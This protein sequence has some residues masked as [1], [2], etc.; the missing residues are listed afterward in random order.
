M[1]LLF[2]GPR[3]LALH[4]ENELN[5]DLL[6]PLFSKLSQRSN[7]ESIYLHNR[8]TQQAQQTMSNVFPTLP[9]LRYLY[10]S[11]NDMGNVLKALSIPLSTGSP[12]APSLLPCPQLRTV[13][14]SECEFE[15]TTERL[16]GPITNQPTL[17]VKFQNCTIPHLRE[18]SR[19]ELASGT[20]HF[21]YE[22]SDSFSEPPFD[23]VDHTRISV[24]HLNQGIMLG[25]NM[26]GHLLLSDGLIVTI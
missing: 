3:P 16:I 1:P 22:D 15:A 18:L 8:V 13:H 9:Y 6:I 21:E 7:I 20:V 24:L 25:P 17:I 12:D 19:H 26:T 5:S 4:L 11:R 2:P 10:C 23:G 14:F